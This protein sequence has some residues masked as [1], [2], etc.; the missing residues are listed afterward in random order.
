MMFMSRDGGGRVLRVFAVAS[1]VGL[2]AGSLDLVVYVPVESPDPIA[3][4]GIG[5]RKLRRDVDELLHDMLI[6]DGWALGLIVLRVSG[7]AAERARQVAVEIGVAQ[8][9]S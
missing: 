4:H 7:T 3:A 8:G 6:D 1:A 2:A 9:A 5:Q